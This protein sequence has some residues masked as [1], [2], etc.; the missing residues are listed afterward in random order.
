MARNP[1]IA[2]PPGL[3]AIS[4]TSEL[5]GFTAGTLRLYEQL[6]PESPPPAPAA[7]PAATTTRTSPVWAASQNSSP[8]AS[9]SSASNESS[10][11]KT[12]PPYYAATTPGYAQTTPTYAGK[13]HTTQ[14]NV[15]DRP[16]EKG[17]PPWKTTAFAQ[18]ST[19][20]PTPTTSN[21]PSQPTRMQWMPS[22]SKPSPLNSTPHGRRPREICSNNRHPP[23]STTNAEIPWS[24]PVHYTNRATT[25]LPTRG[26]SVSEYVVLTA[27]SRTT[28]RPDPRVHT[29]RK[30]PGKDH[31]ML[32]PPRRLY[33]TGHP[34]SPT[35]TTSTPRR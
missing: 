33:L 27:L 20:H 16:T 18:P 11:S 12:A 25:A 32:V 1:A 31:F 2:E 3:Y 21:K 9:T 8:T 26:I 19:R 34:G 29:I 13:T 23:P 28:A 15:R 5:S 22:T 24:R 14:R 6:R 30:P 7:V 10:N 35:P 17:P 4:V